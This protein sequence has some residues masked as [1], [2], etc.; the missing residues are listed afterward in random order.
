MKPRP[1]WMTM[2]DSVILEYLS[3]HDLELPPKALYR[4]LNRQGHE[5]GYSTVRQRTRKLAENGFLEKDDDGYYEISE[6]GEM[7]LSG[8]LEKVDLEDEE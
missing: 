2:S 5:I 4:N 1:E 7:W 3:E 8:D 6:K